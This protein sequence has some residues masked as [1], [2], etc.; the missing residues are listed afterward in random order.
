M[1]IGNSL[2][3]PLPAEARDDEQVTEEQIDALKAT[4]DGKCTKLFQP[5]TK[6]ICDITILH[7]TARSN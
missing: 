3:T 4:P 6:R 1:L 5:T 2:L 7:L